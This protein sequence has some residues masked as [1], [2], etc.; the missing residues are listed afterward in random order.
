MA[1]A[2]QLRRGTTTQ[3]NTFTGLA[4]EVTVDTDK[5]TVVVHD[6]STAGGFPLARASDL[7]NFDADTLDGKQLATIE[8]EYQA[9][10]NTAAANIVDS[11]PGTLDTLN[12]LAA[13]L[14]DD[15]NFATTVT[16]SIATKMPLAGGT[17]TGNVSFGDNNKAI[18]GAGSD[19]QIYH[20]GGNS[21]I[22]EEGSGILFISGS[23]EIQ[24]RTATDEVYIQCI[25]NSGVNL[26]HDN[27]V[28]LATASNGITVTGNVAADSISLNDGDIAYFGTSN[29][30]QIYHDGNHSYIDDQGT[31]NLKIRSGGDS[32]RLESVDGDRMLLAIMDAEVRLY[33]DDAE[34]LATTATG[35][36]VTG[37]AVTDGVT[38]DGTLDIAEVFEKVG[39]T[40]NAASTFNLSLLDQAI[41]YFNADQ[42]TNKTINIRG[43]GSNS[44][45]SVL[46]IGQSATC[47]A[48]L[49]Q[50][51]TAYYINA[52]QVDGSAVT[53]KW[54]GGSAPTGGNASGIDVYTFTIIKT[55]NAT[56]TVLA[57]QSQYA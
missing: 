34:K 35:I 37:T 36:N 50:G 27:A 8:S 39:V 47:T 42:T 51:S 19:L 24:L 43:D 1:N 45:N 25:E 6:G 38:V 2:L 13:A 11:A 55:A 14:G 48:L 18:F 40:Q 29:D 17:F 44:L 10:A 30:L 57:S 20:D 5:E 12:E 32:I 9:F 16:N 7:T 28:K 15:P 4:G 33:Y 22:K 54:S 26:R 52:Y 56:F 49:Q 21:H 31:G 53:P 23:S 3:H 46:S 41:L